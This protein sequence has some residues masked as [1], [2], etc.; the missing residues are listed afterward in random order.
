MKRNATQALPRPH[1]RHGT[2]RPRRGTT[3][4]GTRASLLAAA[5]R[6]FARC[7]Y[8]GASVRA[9]THQAGANL[10]SITYHFGSKHALYEAVLEQ[11]LSPLVDRVRTA[12]GGPGD[13]LDRAEATVRAFF[14]HLEENPDMPQLMLQEIAAGKTPPAP[15][16]RL[17]GGV[18]GCLGQLMAE[19]QVAGEVR[20]GDPVLMALSV[21]YQPVHL[22]LVRRMAKHIVGLDQSD[23]ATHDRVVEHAA[24]FA[25]AGLAAGGRS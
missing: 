22:T 4:P 18:S 10:G 15:V 17:I 16:A 3:R 13:S 24:R 20:S 14:A 6:L 21:V 25:R 8:D 7:G 12:V 9:I 1:G 5:R 11:V 23:P 2:R 19:G